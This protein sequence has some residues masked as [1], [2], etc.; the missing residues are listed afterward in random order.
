MHILVT[1]EFAREYGQ[2]VLSIAPSGSQLVCLDPT[3]DEPPAKLEKAD[4]AFLSL[5]L[6]GG[7]DTVGAHPRLR[8]FSR[9]IEQVPRLRW[10]HTQAAGADRPVLQDALRRGVIVTTSSGVTSETVAHTA[11]AG[12]LALARGVPDWVSAQSRKA[13]STPARAHWPRDINGSKAL[14]IGT[15]P[16]GQAIARILKAMAVHVSGVRRSQD[17]LPGF[18]R[19]LSFDQGGSALPDVD[20]IFLAC[21]LNDRTRGLVDR[22]FLARLAPHAC[23]INVARG[24]V[25]IDGT[26]QSALHAG[27]LGGYYSDVFKDEPLAAA[28]E[29]WETPRTLIS[30]HLAALSQGYGARAA[31][32][33]FEN[34]E[35]YVQ[36]EPLR[37]VVAA[38]IASGSIKPL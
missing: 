16:I 6:M 32:A 7:Q 38:P 33:F 12:M 9:A 4:I 5:D 35:R 13:W 23:L 26:V 25:V 21:P 18:D 30:S 15:G 36:G 14:I 24:E 17:L 8:T 34:L 3:R 22:E 29:W 27:S 1:Q 37:N 28:S 11:I 10:L 31:N 20:W 19:M 2:H